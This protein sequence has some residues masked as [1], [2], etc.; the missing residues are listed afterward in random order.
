MKLSLFAKVY[1]ADICNYKESGLGVAVVLGNMAECQLPSVNRR[2]TVYGQGG[3]RG[4]VSWGKDGV[5][6]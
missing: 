3:V 6:S 4:N 5:S 2:D 1:Y